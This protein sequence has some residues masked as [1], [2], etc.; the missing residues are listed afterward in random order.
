MKTDPMLPA[1]LD[2]VREDPLEIHQQV[3][4]GYNWIKPALGRVVLRELPLEERRGSLWLVNMT[5]QGGSICEVMEVCE[6]YES[7]PDDKDPAA[8]G[9]QYKVGEMV[10]VG[11]F[12]GT[13][14]TVDG[15]KF[16]VC[17]ESDVM[18]TVIKREG[19]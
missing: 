5:Q 13:D 1:A 18:G 6:G 10:V 17:N 8:F 9:P 12:S 14:V 16:I 3:P 4:A 7:A 11:K 15:K 19:I 2:R